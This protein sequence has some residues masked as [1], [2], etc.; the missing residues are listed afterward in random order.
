MYTNKKKK[1]K[2]RR[3]T[4]LLKLKKGFPF[5]HLFRTIGMSYMQ[6]HRTSLLICHAKFLKKDLFITSYERLIGMKINQ[7][8]KE[9]K[10]ERLHY[11]KICYV[12]RH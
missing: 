11:S 9:S 8:M 4:R 1:K 2:R 10:K 6:S 7:L 3:F 5:L 12:Q